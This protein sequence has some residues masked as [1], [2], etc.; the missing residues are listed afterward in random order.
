MRRVIGLFGAVLAVLCVGAAPDPSVDYRV[1]PVM[2]DGALR[3]L[4]VEIRFRGEADGVTRLE[5][6]SHWAGS[7]ELWKHLSEVRVEGA[8]EV[9]EDG[10]EARAI[11]HA[12]G[13]PLVVRYLVNSA[14]ADDP[15]GDYE[16]ARPT[17]R[18][19]WFYAHGE[20]VFAYPSGAYEAP[21]RFAWIGIPSGWRIAS[22]LDHLAAA[23]PGRVSDVHESIMIGAPDLTVVERE[24][25]GAPFRLAML[26][27]WSFTPEVF[28]ERVARIMA[29]ENAFWG[30][31]GRPFF[32]AVSPLQGSG[33][34]NG[35]GRTDAF[36]VSGTTN[37][38]LDE[39]SH[40]LGHEYMHTWIDRELGRAPET[41]E[42]TEYW[43]REGFTDFYAAR[44]LLRSGVWSLEDFVRDQNEML[45]RHAGSPVRT[46]PNA[47]LA[48]RF[49]SD[50]DVDQLPYDRG[51]MFAAMLDHRLRSRPE[52][53]TSLDA[54]LHAQR[55]QAAADASAGLRRTPGALFPVVMR[56]TT[57]M[58]IGD[59]LARYI[60]RGEP[61]PL[62]PAL[63]E[64]CATI[65]PVLQSDFHRGFEIEA[66]QKA[67]G[68]ITG[69]RAD[70]PA[71][72]AGMRDGM[73]LVRRELSTVNDPAVEIGYR[74][75]DSGTERLIRYLPAGRERIQVQRVVLA[76]G[77]DNARRAA[78]ARSMSGG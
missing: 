63:Y 49:W 71:H 64:S 53:R 13:A 46:L 40:F 67:D 74:V 3:R 10:P 20:G 30:D 21:A 31:P 14:Y 70:G 57:G 29:A 78:C 28:A 4:A 42:A 77:L 37:F 44:I 39:L 41:N 35:T 73:K 5:L 19:S 45:T 61:I 9:T 48:A 50:S 7:K 17:I 8:A 51:R 59:L 34:L 2:E 65:N 25:A 36:A 1:T 76:A 22:D 43:L 60:E 12:P 56:E 62:P 33:S 23:R 47:E 75:T 24:V 11:R 68:V 72:A 38:S 58:D 54:V 66:T 52:S 15:P 18:P 69:V 26:G 55:K 6:P 27:R 32:V 16:K